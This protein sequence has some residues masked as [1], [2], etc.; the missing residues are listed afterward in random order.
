MRFCSLGS[1]SAG[2]AML[3][4]WTHQAKTHQILLDCGFSERELIQ[5]L[6][7]RGLSIEALDA[8]LITHEHGD[9]LGKAP[10]IAARH[11][12]E[13]WSTFGTLRPVLIAQT[14]SAMPLR[15]RRL[16]AGESQDLFGMQIE[17][18]AVPH[19][20]SE[21]VQFIFNLARDKALPLRLGVL[22]DL[23]HASA[24]VI[25]RFK[26]LDALVVEANHDV[27]LLEQSGYPASLKKR[28]GGDW[29]HLSN[30]QSAALLQAIDAASLSCVIAAHLSRQNNHPD[31]VR[32]TMHQ[33]LGHAFAQRLIIADQHEGFDWQLA[34]KKAG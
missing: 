28:V 19:D 16:R 7:M 27:Q 33:R 20:A 29:G 24:H 10:S 3:L 9:H 8:I 5:R 22:T 25:A 23:G 18:V 11:G 13:L 12:V 14:K 34:D 21:P 4:Q 1:G 17:A 26:G 30:D 32:S 2:N 15:H 31:R 6:G